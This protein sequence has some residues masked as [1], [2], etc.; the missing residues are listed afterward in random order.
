MPHPDPADGYVVDIGYTHSFH[1]E[2]AP[3]LLGF[4]ALLGVGSGPHFGDGF[5]CYDLGC[6]NGYSTN[7]LA[8]ANP[9]GRFIGLDINPAHVQNARALAA[10]AGIGN[11]QFLQRSFAELHGLELPDAD[12][13]V[14]HGIW[15]WVSEKNRASVMDFVRRKLKPGGIA[16]LSYNCL[17]GTSQ[18]L[19]L[20]RLLKDRIAQEPD[21]DAPLA[22]RIAGSVDFARRLEQAGAAYFRANPLAK[23]RLDDIATR[24]ASYL[25]HEY[26]NDEW[27]AFYHADVARLLGA[28]G[29]DYA[30]SANVIDNFD[31]LSLTS[32][33]STMAAEAPDRAAAETLR[34]FGRNKAFRKD[35]FIRGGDAH[36]RP[37][38]DAALGAMR[39][40]LALP[41]GGCRLTAQTP[42]G[43]FI[44]DSARHAPILDAL[45]RK[46]MTFDALA[47][48]VVV[49]GLKRDEARQALFAMIALGNVHPA[50]SEAGEAARRIATDRFNQAVLA[51]PVSEESITLAS[52]ILGSGVTLGV[53]DRLL[54]TGPRRHQDA[55]D[56][57]LKGYVGA[58]RR[59]IHGSRTSLQALRASIDERAAYFFDDLLPF[60]RLVGIAG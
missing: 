52:P 51:R 10:E 46:P 25:A 57:A 42:A 4:V 29:L 18:M 23:A 17:P 50:L 48:T 15:S 36:S 37:D 41:R 1:P 14:L 31:A 26:Y 56:H 33:M 58:S 60:L 13:V 9:A 43:E 21:G 45:K 7:L 35:V 53:L 49:A 32:A 55:V 59:G 19:P 12:C 3:S 40:A 24:D 28:A 44:L 11:A 39:F 8:A 16:Y 2:L 38:P 54:L 20:R 30:A 22:M 5:V 6:G 27:T 47:R 34:D